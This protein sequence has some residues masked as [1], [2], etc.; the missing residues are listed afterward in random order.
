MSTYIPMNSDYWA[1]YHLCILKGFG[2]WIFPILFSNIYHLD[3]WNIFTRT[4]P[5][6][7]TFFFPIIIIDRV[8]E[9]SGLRVH[10]NNSYIGIYIYYENAYIRVEVISGVV[11]V[12]SISIKT[13]KELNINLKNHIVELALWTNKIIFPFN[14]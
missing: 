6:V 4:L 14:R 2:F 11:W 1:L 12:P 10:N 3:F 13:L 8:Y 9:F 7:R 5:N